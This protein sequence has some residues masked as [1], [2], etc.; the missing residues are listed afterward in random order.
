LAVGAVNH[1]STFNDRP[2][3]DAV[4]SDA[5]VDDVP[6]GRV[7]V[8]HGNVVLPHRSVLE[9]DFIG[10]KPAP[11]TLRLERLAESDNRQPAEVVLEALVDE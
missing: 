6:F 2:K 1:H 4:A 9:L 8:T 3:R 5:A 11:I 7:V 10:D